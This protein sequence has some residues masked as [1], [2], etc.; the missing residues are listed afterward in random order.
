MEKNYIAYYLGDPLIR[1]HVDA[2]HPKPPKSDRF[3]K[4]LVED[5]VFKTNCSGIYSLISRVDMDVNRPI[6]SSNEAVILEFRETIKMIL[7]HLNILNLDKTLIKPY[8]H[9]DFHGMKDRENK[10]IEIGTR[11]GQTCSEN[12]FLW[13]KEKL[14]KNNIL[15]LEKR[16]KIVYNEQFIGDESKYEHRK[17]YGTNFNTI[18][19]EIS[20]TL[21]KYYFNDLIKIFS[22]I[23]LNFS[24]VF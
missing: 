22:N 23:I 11:Y 9:L 18:Q 13:F 20:F 3:T 15:F 12:I 8:L 5:L 4:K 6:D 17:T 1:C 14:E 7:E 16:P 19:I 10:D 24:K 2:L 21:R